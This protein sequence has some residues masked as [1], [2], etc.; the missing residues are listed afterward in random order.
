MAAVASLVTLI[1][2]ELTVVLTNKGEVTDEAI[3]ACM[4]P[5][6]LLKLPRLVAKGLQKKII[7]IK[8][9]VK[10]KYFVIFLMDIGS[11][12]FQKILNLDKNSGIKNVF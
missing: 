10:H 9:L 8:S 4:Y 12:I 11:A 7:L 6:S 1:V 5:G 3:D 2:E